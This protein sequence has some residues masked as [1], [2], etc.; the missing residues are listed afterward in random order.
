MRLRSRRTTGTP[1]DASAWSRPP[2]VRNVIQSRDQNQ[3]VHSGL[4]EDLDAGVFTHRVIGVCGELKCHLISAE[5][6]LDS[7][8]HAGII[9]MRFRQQNSYTVAA[10]V[11]SCGGKATKLPAPCFRTTRLA[12]TSSSKALRTVVKESPDSATRSA[13]VGSLA[14]TPH[15]PARI[16]RRSSSARARNLSSRETAF[17]NGPVSFRDHGSPSMVS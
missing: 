15:V 10:L 11:R 8:E 14:P 3:P 6:L 1:R 5:R 4:E 7:L 13:W 9:E 2:G 12:A 17:A 16:P